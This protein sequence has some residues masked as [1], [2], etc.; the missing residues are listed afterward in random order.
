MSQAPRLSPEPSAKPGKLTVNSDPPLMAFEVRDASM[1]VIAEGITPKQLEVRPGLYMATAI[2]AGAPNLSELVKIAAG[3][4]ETVRL[5]AKDPTTWERTVNAVVDLAPA[6]FRGAPE[7]ELFRGTSPEPK[8]AVLFRVRFF[9]LESWNKVKPI[10]LRVSDAREGQTRVLTI[11][12]A[13]PGTLFA[14]IMCDDRCPLNVELPP[15]AGP[16]VT[17]RLRITA[18][19]EDVCAKLQLE[20]DW[21]NSAA[22]YLSQGYVKQAK[23]VL[24]LEHPPT[25]AWADRVLD[26]F[27]SRTLDPAAG[28]VGRYIRL[29]LGNNNELQSKAEGVADI[30]QGLSDGLIITA[31]LEAR[32]GHHKRALEK[33]LLIEDGK[34]PL[35][36]EGFSIAVARLRQYAQQRFEIGQIDDAEA[37]R[38]SKLLGHFNAW[39]P[40]VDLNAITLTFPGAELTNPTESQFPLKIESESGWLKFDPAS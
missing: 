32:A 22:E 6:V 21:A 28:L 8:S 4:S 20:S 13:T 25:V 31:E 27:R 24:E 17:A 26:W 33:L 40:V 5:T 7:P 16:P 15:V 10:E 9:K 35:F 18:T 38:A 37:R 30:F 36:T 3:A 11:R 34:L 1:R 29:R 19:A 2:R 12:L 23:E 14:Q 39:A